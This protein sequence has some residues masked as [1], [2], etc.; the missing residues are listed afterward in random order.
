MQL[1]VT[2]LYLSALAYLLK[3]LL[4]RTLTSPVELIRCLK[5]IK[6]HAFSASPYPVIITLED[7]LTSDLQAKVAKVDSFFSLMKIF[8]RVFSIHLL[9]SSKTFL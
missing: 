7:H 4:C 8:N 1:L 6:E 5:S 3:N 2:S 9:T